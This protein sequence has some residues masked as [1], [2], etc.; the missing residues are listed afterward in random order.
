VAGAA[1]VGG[2][3]FL[4]RAR[5]IHDTAIND[6]GCPGA[7]ARVCDPKASSVSTANTVSKILYVGAGALGVA[8]VVMIA[9]A[10][11]A[12]PEGHLSLAVSGRF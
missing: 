11:S 3:I 2:T 12:T 8:G 5:S 10:P 4:L 7:G 1:A 6:D 9:V